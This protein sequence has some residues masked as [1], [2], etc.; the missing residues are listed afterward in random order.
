MKILNIHDFINESTFNA[1]RTINST[2]EINKITVDCK[3]DGE[4]WFDFNNKNE[5][6]I[7]DFKNLSRNKHATFEVYFS[8]SFK[9][10][11]DEIKIQGLT[12]LHYFDMHNDDY[13]I[14]CKY[15]HNINA[16]SEMLSEYDTIEQT[17]FIDALYDSFEE[18]EIGE[19]IANELEDKIGIKT[20]DSTNLV[21]TIIDATINGIS[22]SCKY[23]FK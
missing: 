14:E 4:Q 13:D 7:E 18:N 3:W 20:F 6:D 23:E 2:I 9:S 19:T 21:E 5:G 1:V 16:L 12:A 11:E 17:D 10:E 8:I 15:V 22:D